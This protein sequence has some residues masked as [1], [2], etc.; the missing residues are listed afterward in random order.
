MTAAPA[1]AG[2]P[3]WEMSNT[4]K[5]DAGNTD[6]CASQQVQELLMLLLR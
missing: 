1:L 6:K 3:G 4:N 2:R 5:G